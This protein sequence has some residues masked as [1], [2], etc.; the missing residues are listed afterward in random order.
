MPLVIGVDEAGYGPNLG[1]LVIAA[2]AWHVP[3]WPVDWYGQL[4]DCVCREPGDA[5][6]KLLLA[7]SKTAYRATGDLTLLE[8][9][10][11]ALAQL[12]PGMFVP[13]ANQFLTRLQS[14]GFPE[15]QT[16]APAEFFDDPSLQLPTTT[17]LC[18]IGRHAERL[19][20][21]LGREQFQLLALAAR[22]I[23]PAEFNALL[24]RHENKGSLLSASTL[25]LVERLLPLHEDDVQIFCDRHGG[26]AYYAGLIQQFLTS[27]FVQVVSESP[28]RSCYRWQ[29]G[30]RQHQIHFSVGGESELPAA[31]A[32]MIAKYVRELLM[33][34][35]NRFW[36]RHDATLRPTAGYPVDAKRFLREIRGIQSQLAIR[37][38]LVWREK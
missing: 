37:D 6:H 35:W 31:A 22:I 26:R 38:E 28:Q 32:S 15:P 10:V 1:P 18:G 21:G 24:R 16:F 20:A 25:Q 14:A 7:D 27:D 4:A 30:S 33:G 36:R 34:N 13:Q 29:S 19:Q 17:S 3:N 23:P 2:T 8:N 12:L 11:L 5:E 9:A